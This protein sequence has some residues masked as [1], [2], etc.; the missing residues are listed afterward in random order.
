MYILYSNSFFQIL[1][2]PQYINIFYSQ[3]LNALR[4]F[5]QKNVII[6]VTVSSFRIVDV[7]MYNHRKS[8]RSLLF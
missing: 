8:L 5:N 4:I 3:F 7:I 2:V 6:S 1:G